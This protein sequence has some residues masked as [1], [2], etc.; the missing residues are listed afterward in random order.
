M[1]T[2]LDL[3]RVGDANV[4]KG[5]TQTSTLRLLSVV[6]AIAV[7][8]AIGARLNHS[9][10]AAEVG[11]VA[12]CVTTDGS[13]ASAGLRTGLYTVGDDQLSRYSAGVTD[14]NGCG[15]FN[16]VPVDTLFF[17]SAWSADGQQMGNGAWFESDAMTIAPTVQLDTPGFYN[18]LALH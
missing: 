3:L 16:F 6:L 17:V 7:I 4:P 14:H 5:P 10:A 2:N 12:Y 18:R 11:A 15:V 13:P 8:V 9:D 1:E